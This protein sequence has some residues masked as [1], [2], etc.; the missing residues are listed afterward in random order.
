[1]GIPVHGSFHLNKARVFNA[2]ICFF[3]LQLRVSGLFEEEM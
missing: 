1:V 2:K 3:F